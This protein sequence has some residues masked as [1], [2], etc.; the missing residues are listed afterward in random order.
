ML[1]GLRIVGLL[2]LVLLAARPVWLDADEEQRERKHVA[3]LLDRS[4]SMSL[5][6]DSRK[7][8]TD[9]VRFAREQ[10]SPALRSARLGAR[11]LLF[12]EDAQPV[13]GEQIARGQPDGCRC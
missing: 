13:S 9:A 6:D 10:L 3:L 11:S 12:A 8:Y 7:R 1:L 2:L 5:A 4:E